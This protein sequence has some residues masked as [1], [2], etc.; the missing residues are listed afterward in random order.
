MAS[1]E[2]PQGKAR[3]IRLQLKARARHFRKMEEKLRFPKTPRSYRRPRVDI[4]E[5]ELL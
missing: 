1:G 4:F 2:H 5:E 3:R